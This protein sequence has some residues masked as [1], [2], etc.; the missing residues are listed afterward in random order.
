M[1]Q[2]AIKRPEPTGLA[3]EWNR[4]TK[5]F[6]KVFG[7]ARTDP[8]WWL[9]FGVIGLLLYMLITSPIPYAQMLISIQDGIWVTLY[10]T[11]IS[12]FLVLFFGLIAALGRLSRIKLIRGIATVY[13]E[14]IRGI[15]LLV[16]LFFWYYA[17][18]SVIR[19]LGVAWSFQ[20]F[21]EYKADAISMAILG[22]TFC[23]GAY[24]SEIYRAGIQAISKGQMEAARSLGMT[25]FQAMQHVI[26][27]QALRMILP[28]IGNEFFS[29][30]KDSSLV[31]VDAVADMTRRTRDFTAAKFI[32]VEGWTMLA[33]MYLVLTVFSARV[34]T[35]IERKTRIE[36]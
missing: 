30:L 12:F 33:L 4:I 31:S 1:Y 3:G 10:T 15:P 27:P 21:A 19:D 22:L 17:F 23:Y 24:M 6:W 7:F 26:L 34:V 20:P 28:P 2:P 13:V 9:L 36:R 11:L 16:Q 18:P 5:A 32:P 29:L 8:W 25:Y 35:W 14:T